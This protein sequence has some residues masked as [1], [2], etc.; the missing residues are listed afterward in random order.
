MKWKHYLNVLSPLIVML[1]LFSANANGQFDDEPDLQVESSDITFVGIDDPPEVYLG[2]DVTIE[3]N[4]HNV[5]NCYIQLWDR[6]DTVFYSHSFRS[7]QTIRIRL[8]VRSP[9]GSAVDGFAG[10]GISGSPFSSSLMYWEEVTT[11]S[12]VIPGSGNNSLHIS[13]QDFSDDDIEIDWIKI[14]TLVGINNWD[15]YITFEAENYSSGGSHVDGIVP[16]NVQVEFYDGDPDFGGVKIGNTH[17]VGDISK[18]TESGSVLILRE[19]AVATTIENW[20]AGPEGLHDIYVD[21]I[22]D[23][24]ETQTDNNKESKSIEV[25]V[26]EAPTLSEWGLIILCSL[27]LLVGIITLI[28]RSRQLI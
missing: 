13:N 8:K 20:I 23:P 24:E 12:F 25:I 19:G 27:L 2:Q 14:D 3:A 22:P 5:E 4:I 9:N 7:G 16:Q 26:M 21:I 10:V 15:E 11:G 18:T 1:F 28:R 17:T 6:P